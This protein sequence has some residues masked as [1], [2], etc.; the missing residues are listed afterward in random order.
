MKSFIVL[1][2]ASLALVA[3]T[4]L[5]SANTADC[6]F[7]HSDPDLTPDAAERAACS[8]VGIALNV[9]FEGAQCVLTGDGDIC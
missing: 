8:V 5:A 4:P 2:A 6:E 1:I 3:A 9:V 7:S